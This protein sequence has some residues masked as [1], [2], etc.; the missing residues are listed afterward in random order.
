MD[1]DMKPIWILYGSCMDPHMDLYMADTPCGIFSCS[2][3][4]ARRCLVPWLL[5]PP[6]AM[7][8]KTRAAPEPAALSKALGA[9]QSKRNKFDGEGKHQCMKH[10]FVAF[11]VG[12]QQTTPTGE[13]KWKEHAKK[14]AFLLEQF[15]DH[16][17]AFI[18]GCELGGLRQGVAATQRNMATLSAAHCRLQ[19]GKHLVR[20]SL[21]TTA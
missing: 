16:D 12:V 1:A 20:T 4:Q 14:F 6:W 10:T 15:A 3:A 9:F 17:A 21:S 2:F 11:N 18:F 8:H 19:N 7:E 13:Q 5:M